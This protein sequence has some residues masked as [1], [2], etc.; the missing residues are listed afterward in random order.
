GQNPF[1]DREHDAKLVIDIIDG[2]RPKIIDGT[3]KDLV[4]LMEKC[5]DPN[6]NKRPSAE[7]IR[8]HYLPANHKI[9][10]RKFPRI[11][12]IPSNEQYNN[13]AIY[14]NRLLTDVINTALGIQ[15][16]SQSPIINEASMLIT[17]D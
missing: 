10:G 7:Y 9:Y 1:S 3:S 2:L 5:W 14:T 12:N 4:D 15:L 6:P 16:Q 11:E 13:Q 8:K 17:S